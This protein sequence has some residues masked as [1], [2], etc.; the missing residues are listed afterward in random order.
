MPDDF[1]NWL[2]ELSQNNEE[3]TQQ[4]W[5]LYFEKL[6]RLARRK[7]DGLPLRTTDEEDIALSAM[8]SFC[9]GMAAHR[10][11]GIAEA[12]EL[13]KLLVTITA[14]KV[15]AQRRLH[16]AQ[17]RGGG[18]VRG[19]SIFINTS[20][21]D[22]PHDAGIGEVL[23]REPTPEFAAGF[24]E[25]CRVMIDALEDE[26]LKQIVILTL[27]GYRVPEIAE[28]LGCARRTVERKLHIVR[29]KWNDNSF[30]SE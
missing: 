19:E 4:L 14:R 18:K 1:A 6:V 29:E 16:F 23:G 3:A 10:F 8:Y 20:D 11:D 21:H 7:L 9:R 26:T 27:E 5:E 30:C 17:K 28:K 15:C 13:W 24:A 25:N 2:Q 22:S 12:G